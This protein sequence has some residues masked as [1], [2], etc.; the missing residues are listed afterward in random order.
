MPPTIEEIRKQYPDYQD[1]SDDQLAEKLH[2][3]FYADMPI[4][5]FRGKIGLST[6]STENKT[7]LSELA[8][9]TGTV[10]GNLKQWGSDLWDSTKGMVQGASNIVGQSM[11]RHPTMGALGVI[12][13]AIEDMYQGVSS[14]KDIVNR[15]GQIVSSSI[16]GG[17]TAFDVANEELGNYPARSDAERGKALRQELANPGTLLMGA[18]A[19]KEAPSLTRGTY[20]GIRDKAIGMPEDVR[21]GFES[22]NAE[23]YGNKLNAGEGNTANELALPRGAAR[24]QQQF[25]DTNP[26]RG[27]DVNSP[28]PLTGRENLNKFID[29][30]DSTKVA[31]VNERNA[32]LQN[33]ATAEAAKLASAGTTPIKI[34]VTFD[35]LPQ[36]SIGHKGQQYTLQSIIDNVKGGEA[37]VPIATEYVQN[38]FGISP[39]SLAG[40]DMGM[41]QSKA[42][43]STEL[44]TLRKRLDTQIDALGGYDNTLFNQVVPGVPLPA[45]EG[46]IE[47]LRFYRSQ[48]DEALKNHIGNLLGDDVKTAFDTAGKNIGMAKTYGPLAERFKIETGQAYAPGSS[49]KTPPGQGALLGGNTGFVEKSIDAVVPGAAKARVETLGLQ[50]EQNALRQ[51]QMLIDYK[52]GN[53]NIPA[54]R[55]WD[56][57]KTSAQHLN[58][59]G[60]IAMQMGLIKDV[61]DLTNMPDQQAKQVVGAVASVMPQAFEKTPDNVN[62]IDNE[63]MNPMD[64]DS[65]VKKALDKSPTE[66]ARVIGSSFKNK[67]SPISEVN[68]PPPGASPALPSSLDKINQGLS[69]AFQPEAQEDYSYG[70][71]TD[72]MLSQ[73]QKM[74]NLH[75]VQ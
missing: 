34:G 39:Q 70:H 55:G 31:S 32:I 45:K 74:T 12:P 20:T 9:G 8:G 21:L 51:L 52:S 25:T 59:V 60:M 7:F 28:A 69:T 16:P 50:R 61:S 2:A 73:L 58:N 26:L 42:L 66:R 14:A 46:Y 41:S 62:V 68:E 19:L 56:Q 63:Y 11:Q 4:D 40:A 65:V 17:K 30:L 22:Q 23:I 33:A 54:P 3:K 27:I 37:G 47:A 53:L 5:Q 57:I 64:K 36:V 24:Y 44:N 67:Y 49:K 13:T 15:T 48:V 71:E 18:Q 43:S 35:D 6:T 75:N 1:L 29:N 10:T 72:S 38:E